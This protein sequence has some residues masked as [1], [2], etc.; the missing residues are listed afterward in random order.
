MANSFAHIHPL[1]MAREIQDRYHGYLKT[2]FYFR[3]PELRQ[4]FETE[5]QRG[6]LVNGPFL[7]STPVYAREATTRAL[8]RETLTAN[9]DPGFVTS[10][11]PDRMLYVHQERA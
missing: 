6:R 2:S 9:V 5:L 10:L 1:E 11:D 8:L 4:S 7:E 3:D